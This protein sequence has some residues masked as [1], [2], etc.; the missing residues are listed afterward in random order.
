MSKELTVLLSG[1]GSNMQAIHSACVN[2]TIE[3]QL[4]H[5]IS[6]VADAAGLEYAQHHGIH[7][8]IVDHKGYETREQFDQAL[9]ATIDR[10]S[11]PALIV[12]AGFM[13][14][15]TPAFTRHYNHRLI[16][17]HP[18]L[19]PRYPGL[20]THARALQA[21]DHW[22]G[23]S[24]HYVNEE[25]DGGP[26]IARGIVPIAEGDTVETLSARVLAVEHQLYP[27]VVQHCLQS[28]T[29]CQN[30]H[31]KSNDKPELSPLLYYY[32]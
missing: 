3:A 15:L 10:F 6:N 23:C 8:S 11:N 30:S 32:P 13:R 28:T 9:I 26:V 20:N 24:V 5:V 16:N 19:L 17:I 14:R 18:S 27:E 12:L 31:V 7:T 1:R 25:L 21:H 22:H 4:T 2:D 29:E